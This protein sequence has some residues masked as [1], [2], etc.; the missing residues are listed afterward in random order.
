MKN[1]VAGILAGIIVLIIVL[2]LVALTSWFLSILLN[3]VLVQMGLGKITLW[4]GCCILASAQL[5][6]S[7]ICWGE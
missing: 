3:V 2:G 1:F 5:I 7:F 6:K 4:G